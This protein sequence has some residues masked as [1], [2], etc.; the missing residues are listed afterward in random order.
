MPRSRTRTRTAAAHARRVLYRQILIGTLTVCLVVG[1]LAGVWHGSRSPR[2]TIDTVQVA[3]THT[4][5]TSTVIDATNRVLDGHYGFLVPHRFGWFYPRHDIA[6]E[7][8]AL[9]RVRDAHVSRRGNTVYVQIQEH[10][11]VALWCA[12]EVTLPRTDRAARGPCV[13]VGEHGEA[14]AVAPP[15]TGSVLRRYYGGTPTT[16]AAMPHAVPWLR[17]LAAVLEREHNTPVVAVTKVAETEYHLVLAH[18][19]FIKV[20]SRIAPETTIQNL[21]TILEAP[22]YQDLLQHP[23]HYIDLRYETRA[24]VKRATT[25]ATGSAQLRAP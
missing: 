6:A 19:G 4:L 15:L 17:T 5:A 11:P 18:G 24:Y 12:R 16:T 14:F 2:F 3:G 8:R 1:L 13:Y 21:H 10:Q 7:L 22:A 9:P 25:T 23:F 20:S